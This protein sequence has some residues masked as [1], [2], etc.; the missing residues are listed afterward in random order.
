MGG[1]DEKVLHIPRRAWAYMQGKSN[2]SVL[3]RGNRRKTLPKHRRRWVAETPKL[4][5]VDQ[6]HD[7]VWRQGV[8]IRCS[9]VV[10]LVL[11]LAAL[12]AFGVGP[13]V[14]SYFQ[15]YQ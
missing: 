2:I 13:D 4:G 3:I 5:G 8:R 11:A 1:L 12:A 10:A 14:L 6:I 7:G 9:A 15:G